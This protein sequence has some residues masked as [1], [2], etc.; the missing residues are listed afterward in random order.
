M[1]IELMPRRT[2]GGHLSRVLGTPTP[3]TSDDMDP[4]PIGYVSI[5]KTPGGGSRIRTHGSLST[6]A[7]FKTAA[8]I[9]LC[10]TS[11]KNAKGLEPSMPWG[12][13]PCCNIAGVGGRWETRTPAACT[14]YGLSRPAPDPTG[15]LPLVAIDAFIGFLHPHE[16]V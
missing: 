1:R 2:S 14:T 10:H 13:A 7:V 5:H 11:R 15:H 16:L 3:V 6:P 12:T 8:I 4:Y 9:H